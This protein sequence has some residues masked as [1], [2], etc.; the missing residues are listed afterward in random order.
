M[1]SLNVAENANRAQFGRDLP[2]GSRERTKIL[3]GGNVGHQHQGQLAFFHKPLD[4]GHAQP[5]GHFP[6]DGADLVTRHV[7][8]DLVEFNA[9][10]LENGHVLTG[11]HVSHLAAGANL[12]FTNPLEDFFGKHYGK[13]A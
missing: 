11:Q 9:A 6:V 1:S 4:V 8:P 7:G 3:G 10:S 12:D 5:S 13:G 2:L